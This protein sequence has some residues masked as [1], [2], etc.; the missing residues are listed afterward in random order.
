MRVFVIRKCR[1]P[2]DRYVSRPVR[3]RATAQTGEWTHF[4][5]DD[6][7]KMFLRKNEGE[8]GNSCDVKRVCRYSIQS[9]RVSIP[10]AL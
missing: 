10:T 8:R 3:S 9:G 1:F 2:Q 5:M 4:L 7:W 6:E